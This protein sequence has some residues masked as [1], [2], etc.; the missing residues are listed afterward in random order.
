MDERAGSASAY[1]KKE[2]LLLGTPRKSR[3][4]P[5]VG[6]LAAV[7]AIGLIGFVAF[8][9]YVEVQ[10]VNVEAVPQTDLTTVRAGLGGVVTELLQ[11]PGSAVKRGEPL[12]KIASHAAGANGA[13]AWQQL[14]ES[15]ATSHQTL[16]ERISLVEARRT[17]ARAANRDRQSASRQ[18][19]ASLATQ[20][21]AKQADLKLQEELLDSWADAI[22]RHYISKYAEQSQREV[23]ASTRQSLAS[24][25]D[26]LVAEKANLSSLQ[27]QQLIDDGSFDGESASYRQQVS[28]QKLEHDRTAL[29]YEQSLLAPVDGY[30]VSVPVRTGSTVT[31][32]MPLVSIAPA[33]LAYRLKGNLPSALVGWIAEGTRVHLRYNA[34][35]YQIYGEFSGKVCEVARAPLLAPETGAQ[36]LDTMFAFAV[37]PDDAEIVIGGV[38]RPVLGLQAMVVLTSPPRR[39][40]QWLLRS[41]DA[42]VSRVATQFGS[43]S[44]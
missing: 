27:K 11:G 32:G 10:Y 8:G 2:L 13:G 40:Y 25:G 44:P 17:A 26:G 1:L 18:K 33:G 4:A 12:L 41:S 6:W 23:I 22:A 16:L 3:R 20:I 21:A 15:F 37:C 30:V 39:I 35:P 5:A 7:V 42:L 38:H 43:G 28:E 9:R 31:D 34:Y 24:L 36:G 29:G 19:I 14:D